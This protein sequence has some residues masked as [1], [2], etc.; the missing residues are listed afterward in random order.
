M[1][2]G[3]FK[4]KRSRDTFSCTLWWRMTQRIS[5]DKPVSKLMKNYKAEITIA[6]LWGGSG[7]RIQSCCIQNVQFSTTTTKLRDR[8]ENRKVLPIYKRKR[9][10]QKLL[11]RC[12]VL[13]SEGKGTKATI[14]NM[15]KELKETM[16]KYK[17]KV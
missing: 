10:Q 15:Y 4:I 14:V 5:T 13:N 12:P 7:I 1:K 17:R 3:I 11:L 8:Q 9:S 16:F 2:T 6:V